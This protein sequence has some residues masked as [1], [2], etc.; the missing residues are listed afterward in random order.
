MG[1]TCGRTVIAS[2]ALRAAEANL[3]AASAEARAKADR[4]YFGLD[5]RADFGDPTFSGNPDARGTNVLAAVAA[6]KR[7]GDANRYFAV[8]ARVGAAYADLRRSKPFYSLDYGL[9]IELGA[10]MDL[11]TAGLTAGVEGRYS[12]SSDAPE[13]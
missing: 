5:L 12:N 10:V 7:L 13:D 8:R 4:Q 6:G 1:V 2:A 11:Q 9:G 3:K